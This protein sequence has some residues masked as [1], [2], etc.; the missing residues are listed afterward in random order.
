MRGHRG[1]HVI[2]GAL[3][4]AFQLVGRSQAER[5][6]GVGETGW[7]LELRVWV[8]A[9]LSIWLI[10]V[11]AVAG[12]KRMEARGARTWGGMIVAFLGYMVITSVWAPDPERAAAKVYD[13]LFV[14]WSAALMV[15][16]LRMC[17]VGP[18]IE[19]F[20]RGLY[21]G[22]LALAAIGIATAVGN[23]QGVT[24]LSVLSGGPNV[25]G[26]NMG[27]L[28]L[29]SLH[30]IFDRGRLL[31]I[32]GL[33]TAP[34]AALLV[35]LSGSRGAMLA[36]FFGVIVYLS[37]HRVDRK[38]FWSLL[39]VGVAGIAALATRFGELAVLVFRERFLILLLA[40]QYFTHRDVL[41][42]E[43]LRA[44]LQ[45][46]FGGL[47]LSGFATVGTR[48][49]HPHNIFLEA[50]SEGGFPG[51][52]LLCLPFVLYASRWRRGMGRR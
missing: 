43:G 28:A 33:V 41:L 31:R 17:G 32:M 29:V 51:L 50:F 46:P 8:L 36:L 37:V 15:A 25:F 14:I 27:L 30:L 24:R 1:V 19:G 52:V 10:G 11:A 13:V 7:Y 49:S 3:I 44:G 42:L 22:G 5:F 34:L 2:G 18:T 35:L 16:A 40:E 9:T 45:H 4:A 47:G 21:T 20:W 23:S 39:A 26:R 48:G 6:I 38:V 12:T